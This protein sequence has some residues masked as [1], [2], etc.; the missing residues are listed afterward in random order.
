MSF[1]HE[2]VAAPTAVTV[3]ESEAGTW[4][5]GPRPSGFIPRLQELWQFRHLISY[6]GYR[7]LQKLYAGTVLGWAWVILRPL[8][9]LATGALI[10]G[11]FIGVGSG[12]VPYFLF[13]L[14][15][16][17][18]WNLFSNSLT[19]TTRSLEL[20]RKIL[21]RMYFPRLVL[22]VATLTPAL[23]ETAIYI[24]IGLFTVAYYW[25][26][27]GEPYVALAPRLLLAPLIMV[28]AVV[29]ALGIGL[30]TSVYG[31]TARDARFTVNYVLGFWFYLTPVIYPVSFVPQRWEW[32]LWLNPMAA[33]QESFRWTVLGVG[34]VQPWSIA[35]AAT[36]SM[37]ALALGLRFFI[38]AEAE[39][40]DRL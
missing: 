29:L 15:G 31:A 18:L 6:F 27:K 5:I 8:F 25:L 14:V 24:L 21:Q 37:C 10:F 26:T 13:F 20:N 3:P 34:R 17:T 32:L 28:W 36:V 39:S 30:W 33:L 4:V 19:W 23:V 12:P 35:T 40:V 11:D 1:K 7:A 16:S 9:P 2:V 22:P 38:R